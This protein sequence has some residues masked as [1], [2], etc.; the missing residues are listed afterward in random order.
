MKMLQRLTEG[1]IDTRHSVAVLRTTINDTVI[2][3]RVSFSETREKGR[4]KVQQGRRA[5][6]YLP[7]T[8]Y[9]ESS[10]VAGAP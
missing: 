1:A 10:V 2:L 5:M 4:L 8:F 9:V 3:R 7:S 6:F